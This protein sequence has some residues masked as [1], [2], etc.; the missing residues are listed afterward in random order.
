MTLGDHL[1]E[2]RR[3]FL[4]S[5]I[6]VLLGGVLGWIF[7]P[8]VYARLAAPF[9]DYKLA[10]PQSVISL[11]FGNATAAFSQQVSLSIFV[12]VIAS[13]PVWLYQVWAFIL[14]GLTKK[15]RNISLAFIAAIFPLFLA[16]CGLAYFVLPAVLAVLYG[17]TPAGASNIQQVSEY[18]SF[19]T[20][21]ILVFGAAFLLPVFLVAL[22]AIGILPASAMLKA[23]RPAIFGIF[24]L[25]AIATPTPDAFT[26]F[27][28]AIPLT[29]LYFVAILVSK[30]IE[31]RKR[32]ARPDWV[33]VPDD[34]ASTL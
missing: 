9:N 20:R 7:Y 30:L 12:G 17:F 23:W 29:V 27:L 8:Q 10:N 5:A 4:I 2:L 6:A 31:R 11:N 26:M 1:R 22:N 18:F 3:R 14:P 28:M 16:G 13:S 33:E 32:K 15:E 24:V 19:V 34:E 21:F 25:S